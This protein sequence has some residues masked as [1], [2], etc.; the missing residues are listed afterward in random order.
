MGIGVITQAPPVKIKQEG[1]ENKRVRAGMAIGPSAREKELIA[2][3]A[4]GTN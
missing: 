2:S 1:D 3:L 4:K